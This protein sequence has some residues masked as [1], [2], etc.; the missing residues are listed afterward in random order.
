MKKSRKDDTVQRIDYFLRAYGVRQ[1]VE[2]FVAE[3]SNIYH[4][5]EAAIYDARHEGLVHS[6]AVW[7]DLLRRTASALPNRIAVLDF[8][9]GTGFAAQQAIDVFG[10]RIKRLDCHDPSPDMLAVCRK[11]IGGRM[12]AGKANF[13]EG[14]S[15]RAQVEASQYDLVLTNAVLHHVLDLEAFF[16]MIDRIV[17]PGGVYIAGHEPNRRFYR[18]RELVKA[19]KRFSAYKKVKRRFTRGFWAAKLGGQPPEEGLEARVSREMLERDMIPE[20][21]PPGVIP[22]L[23]DIHVPIGF[24]IG[25]QRWGVNGFHG[26]RIVSDYLP[27]FKLRGF[28]SYGHIKDD[29]VRRDPI[30]RRMEASLAAKFPNDGADCAMVFQKQKPAPKKP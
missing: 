1:P 2:A 18:N 22:K 29:S 4:K 8:G 17:A 7:R 15:G 21:L 28:Q 23:V 11:N 20:P 10:E 27:N 14:E 5:H 12:P 16:A 24:D 25:D 13:L 26:D 19:S 9:C 6:R 30:W 3:V